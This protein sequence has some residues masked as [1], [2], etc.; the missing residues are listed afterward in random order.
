MVL[1]LQFTGIGKN[2]NN[3]KMMNKRGQFEWMPETGDPFAR[4]QTI[5][6]YVFTIWL[7]CDTPVPYGVFT[8]FIY[9][10]VTAS[11]STMICKF[12]LPEY[13]FDAPRF[14]HNF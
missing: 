12:Q 2:N 13:G 5:I 11:K 9:G 8:V 3:N 6:K 1:Q 14:H 7:H 10:L 4:V